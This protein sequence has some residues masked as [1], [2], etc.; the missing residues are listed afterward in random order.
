MR[1]TNQI[2]WR[3]LVNH[4][5][6]VWWSWINGKI[7]E[8][9]DFVACFRCHNFLEVNGWESP[10]LLEFV[11]PWHHSIGIDITR[12]NWVAVDEAFVANVGT[13][14]NFNQSS[15]EVRQQV[16]KPIRGG[17]LM[18]REI[19]NAC[20]R[21]LPSSFNSNM[22]GTG[23]SLLLMSWLEQELIHLMNPS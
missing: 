17:T 8:L 3:G 16:L 11:S 4:K 18:F 1:W 14:L 12:L 6:K 2:E 5:A 20:N 7:R 15:M 22:Y 9:L 13:C 19:S 23:H 10:K 21:I